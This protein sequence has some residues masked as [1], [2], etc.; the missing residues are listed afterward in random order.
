[1]YGRISQQFLQENTCKRIKIHIRDVPD[2]IGEVI[3]FGDGD[4]LLKCDDGKRCLVDL[5][6]VIG[7]TEV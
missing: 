7:M 1:M 3:S 2:T 6:A 5:G 4:I